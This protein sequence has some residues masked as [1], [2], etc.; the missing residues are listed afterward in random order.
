[1]RFACT[2]LALSSALSLMTG[3]AGA[4]TPLTLAEV[5]A[6][7]R[8]HAPQV[9]AARLA[10]DEARG[11][12]LGAGLRFQTNPDVELG[13]GNRTGSSARSTD[14]E[15][16]VGQLFEPAGR[17]TAR[18]A[19]ARAQIGAR[20][21]ALDE[22][23][24]AVTREVLAAFYS[25]LH[26]NE[27]IRLL[28]TTEQLAVRMHEVADRRFRAGDLAVLDV[29][30]ARSAVAR[31]RA[32]R[33]ATEAVRITSLGEI[34]SLLGLEGPIAVQGS[35]LPVA[36][37]DASA[38]AQAAMLR[39]ELQSL[40]AELQEADADTQLARTFSRPDYTIGARYER[41]G[42]DQILLG[43]LTVSLPLFSTG[44]E[45]RAVGTARA[46]RLRTE[47]TA[48]R[49][50]V[51]TELRTALDSYARRLEALRIL[52]REALPTLEENEALAARSFEVG[53]IGLPD[54]L[55]IHREIQDTQFQFLDAQLEA[56]FA[57]VNV[58]AAAAV[59]R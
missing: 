19:S 58:D 11:R 23:T 29:N 44:Q 17:R 28:T 13:L 35:L 27:R 42:G 16:G 4:Q 31:I 22:I 59:L 57:R 41:E 24:R 39:P 34:K 32:N 33:E 5:V 38:L 37:P 15:V 2:T 20:T 56:A 10:V 7:A 25:T 3:T 52:Q 48:A 26:A 54:L 8:E 21:A 49:A 50:R 53:Q 6:R 40:E 1:M 45:L 18:T 14:L 46:T 9:V 47:L 12:L 36:E 55:L 30:I 43:A 51:Q